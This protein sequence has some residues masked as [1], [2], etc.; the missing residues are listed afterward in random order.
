MNYSGNILEMLVILV[1]LYIYQK[2]VLNDDEADG[3]IGIGLLF[4]ATFYF[5]SEGKLFIDYVKDLNINNIEIAKNIKA[6]TYTGLVLFI[7][8]M[9]P[10]MDTQVISEITGYFVLF[11]IMAIG[12]GAKIPFWA[13]L[14]LYAVFNFYLNV[15]KAVDNLAAK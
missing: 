15:Y 8:G 13:F 3:F 2:F 6:Y 5:F 10:R 14:P 9:V 1:P 7:L 11:L 12:L 4:F